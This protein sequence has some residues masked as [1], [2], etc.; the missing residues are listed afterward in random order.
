[1]TKARSKKV[2]K[3]DPYPTL[4]S[5]PLTFSIQCCNAHKT[6]SYNLEVLPLQY[7]GLS[8]GFAWSILANRSSVGHLHREKS[9]G[10]IR[11]F[12]KYLDALDTSLRPQHPSKIDASL[13]RHYAQWLRVHQEKAHTTKSLTYR[14]L[15]VLIKRWIGRPW[16]AA[17]LVI[18]EGQFPGASATAA[19][20]KPYSESEL[21]QIVNAVK[22]DL[23]ASA[24]KFE[25]PYKPK[26]INQPAP[27]DDVAPYNE[28][29]PFR[30]QHDP[31][32][33]EDYQIWWWENISE[34][35]QLKVGE[36]QR[37]HKGNSFLRSLSGSWNR[38]KSTYCGT[39]DRLIHFYEKIGAGENYIPKFLGKPCPIKY[40]NRW[41]KFEYL[42]WY[43]E[44][45][46]ACSVD[47]YGVMRKK[48]PRFV[49]AIRE[50]HG[51]LIQFFEFVGVAHRITVYDL[52]PYYIGL[53]IST[54]LNPSTV[55]NLDI[56]C[57]SPDP[58][59]ARK[60]SINWTKLRARNQGQ[61]IPAARLNGLSPVSLVERLIAVT[62]PIRQDGQG[63]LFITNSANAGSR[64]GYSL[65]KT[66]FS[67]AVHTW[68]EN[69]GIKN[70]NGL[71]EESPL[72]IG[73][74][75]RFRNTIAQHEYRRTGDLAYVKTLLSHSRSDLTSSYINKTGD[76]ILRF[77][78]GIHLEALFVGI[79]SN[80]DA[81]NSI[82]EQH[83]LSP[84]SMR[85]AAVNRNWHESMVAHC[86]DPKTSPVHG[87]R[88][89]MECNAHDVCLYCP[90]LVVTSH[91]LVRHFAFV[92]Y[93]EHLLTQGALSLHEFNNAVSERRHMFEEYI[94]P[95]Y[96]EDAV[97]RARE[98]AK[99]HP[100]VEWKIT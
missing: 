13:L 15:T 44:N 4:E 28:S 38:S 68:F 80:R 7:V 48:Y 77:R 50:H 79:T 92:F 74:S 60:L 40:T 58:L 71:L 64:N 22:K 78:R 57:L 36:I 88:P 45:Y 72:S 43:W 98:E 76:P 8:R 84:K 19:A 3:L 61:S 70:H 18:P 14:S 41:K 67:R 30:L 42:Q 37:L 2:S 99:I 83:G 26:Y 94:L 9:L 33:S 11:M 62:R 53:L 97:I 20:R 59:D 5:V 21:K 29:L 85:E 65:S 55:R 31:W 27:V 23:H 39:A 10:A 66:M 93:H 1:V 17:Q 89:G 73:S 46:C 54:A 52:V 81:A 47:V 82:I 69:H 51:S 32:Q 49:N 24:Q 56:D 35:R 96:G 16:A 90:N 25:R 100:P 91:D 75:A 95:R 87:Q 6:Y 63:K 86:R 34:C 12:Y